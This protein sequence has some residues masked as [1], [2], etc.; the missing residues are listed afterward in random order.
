MR[1]TNNSRR[2]WSK[3]TLSATMS[4]PRLGNNGCPLCSDRSIPENL[5]AHVNDGQTC[6][7][8]HLQLAMLRYDNAM[9][10]VGQEKYQELCCMA[11]SSGGFKST[12]GFMIGAVFAGFFLKKVVSSRK[13]RIREEMKIYD[14]EEVPGTV[15]FSSRSSRN[16]SRSGTTDLEMPSSCYVNMD[17]QKANTKMNS[18]RSNRERRGRQPSRSRDRSHVQ[19]D[20]NNNHLD[21]TRPSS[22]SRG[23]RNDNLS[24]DRSMSCSR[25]RENLET[26]RSSRDRPMSRSRARSRSK[27]RDM[28]EK[29][30]SNSD[31]PMSRSRARSNS[32]PRNISE[33]TRSS[34]DRPKSRSRARS[35]SRPR[36]RSDIHSRNR[37]GT[38][39]SRS[40]SR[41]RSRPEFQ[42][43]DLYHGDVPRLPTQVL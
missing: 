36:I 40:R 38:G 34:R 21:R 31:R 41:A 29:T 39:R 19:Y 30:H 24:R 26:N 16:S 3:N 18:P 22:R 37:P 17:K 13:R 8:V 1:K 9:C 28:S 4:T 33:R 27:L 11:K 2:T 23:G 25:P 12:L 20:N 42:E 32:R 15:S 7:D 43:V 35:R 6:A 5:N 10:A 14:N